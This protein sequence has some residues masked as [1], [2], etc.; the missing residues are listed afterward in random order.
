MILWQ[1]NR[2]FFKCLLISC[3]GMHADIQGIEMPRHRILTHCSGKV[4]N[5]HRQFQAP[6]YVHRIVPACSQA[7]YSSSTGM[8][9]NEV[10]LN[11]NQRCIGHVLTGGGYETAYIGK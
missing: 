8:V 5:L 2:I 7:K 1:G 11:P 10:R 6:R 4:W 3:D 9:I